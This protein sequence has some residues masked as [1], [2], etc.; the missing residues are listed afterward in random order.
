METTAKDRDA[1]NAAAQTAL[2]EYAAG[3]WPLLNHKARL[4]KL[5]RKLPW[6]DRRVRA[7]YNGEQ[8]VS[9]R[10]DEQA[11]LDALTKEA[12][13][14]YRTIEALCAGLEALLT[15]TDEAGYRAQI[16]ALRQVYRGMDRAG[17]D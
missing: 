5:C 7:I 2:R 16:D 11:E 4:A 8:G 13:H 3:E 6:S 10:A 12:R 15:H 17:T 14:E 9:L 1:M